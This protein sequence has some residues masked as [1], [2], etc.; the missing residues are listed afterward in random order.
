MIKMHFVHTLLVRIF[1]FSKYNLHFR[2]LKINL[3]VT[4]EKKNIYL[5]RS[6]HCFVYFSWCCYS[7]NI[8]HRMFPKVPGTQRELSRKTGKRKI[9]KKCFQR[10]RRLVPCSKCSIHFRTAIIEAATPARINPMAYTFRLL[11]SVCISRLPLSLVSREQVENSV[12][13]VR[14]AWAEFG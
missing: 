8:R 7:T 12:E 1:F 10:I 3:G 4:W 13:C 5:H 14:S 6:I 2:S 11:Q 9:S